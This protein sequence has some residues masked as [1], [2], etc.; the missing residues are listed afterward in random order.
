MT[1]QPIVHKLSKAADADAWLEFRRR[2]IGGSDVAAIC[3]LNPYRGALRVWLEK[4]GQSPQQ[5][6]TEAMELGEWL[7]DSIAEYFAKK[8]GFAIRQSGVILQHPVHTFMLASIDRWVDEGGGKE[9]VLEVKNVGERMA[10]EWLDLEGD[11][12]VPD[13]YTLQ[14]QHYLAVTGADYAWVAPL[15]GGNRLK[16]VR[17]ARDD[18]LIDELIE[19]ERKFW[20]LVETDQAPAIDD[21]KE[22]EEVLR[23]VHPESTAGKSIELDTS[24]QSIY[25]KLSQARVAESMLKTEIQGY[26]N[27]LMEALGD[28]E[29]AYIPGQEKPVVTYR[30]SVTRRFNSTRF[31]SEH[32]EEAAPYY[33]ESTSRRF[34]VKGEVE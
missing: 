27:L 19:I 18:R 3:G 15:I 30:G 23:L 33:T 32:P 17:L 13:Y 10:K 8:K 22:A 2:G 7:E 26:K 6:T 1:Y 11:N 12:S 21:S 16:P 31:V 4:K 14:V 28:A 24:L 29:E 25:K 5:E 34:L 20:N 9:G